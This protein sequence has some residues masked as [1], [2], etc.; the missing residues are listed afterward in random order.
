MIVKSPTIE[1]AQDTYCSYCGNKFLEQKAWPRKCF[2]CWNESYKNPIPIVVSM[3]AIQPSKF[4]DRIGLLIQRRNIEPKKGE[5]ALPSGYINHGE[6]WQEA[7]VRENEEEM[8]FSSSPEDYRLWD[9]KKPTSGNMLI[10]CT[11]RKVVTDRAEELITR[12]V[13]NSEV[14]A[15]GMYHDNKGWDCPAIAFPTHQDG[16]DARLIELNPDYGDYG[17]FN[18]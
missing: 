5:W 2:T 17:G 18:V 4:G 1:Y 12:F 15:L 9:I 8:N 6:T 16:A 14:L 13:P 7:A 11:Y 10:F 3:I